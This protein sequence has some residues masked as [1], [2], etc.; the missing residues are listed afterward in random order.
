MKSSLTTK[1]FLIFV[2]LFLPISLFAQVEFRG[3]VLDSSTQ[4]GVPHASVFLA[5]STI[6]ISTDVNGFFSLLIPD[7]D[8]EVIVRLVGYT[9][10][11]FSLSTL[12]INPDGFVIYLKPS[13]GELDF[14]EVED[15]RDPIWY[16]NLSLF[17]Q[18][19]LG[20]T[21]NGKETRILNQNI[22]RLDSESVPL[23]LRV[24]TNDVLQIENPNL[25]YRVEY[26]LEEFTYSI[27]KGTFF[28]SGFSRFIPDS[29]LKRSK[30]KRIESNRKRAYLGSMQHL[31]KSLYDGTA[32]DEGFEFRT[33]KRIKNPGRPDQSL[34]DESKIRF[35]QSTNIEEKDSLNKYF[36]RKERLNPFVDVLKDNLV[37]FGDLVRIEKNGRIF[38]NFEDLLHVT[39]TKE[40]ETDEYLNQFPPKKP[41]WQQ[42]ILRLGNN[43][44]IEIFG[45]GTYGNR[46]GI[47][48]EGY[49]GWE[50]VGDLMPLDYSYK[51]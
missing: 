24:N 8:Y 40:L 33:I 39:F 12:N 44:E 25:G 20:N 1:H 34:I 13:Y 22:L 17:K 19:F 6:G 45:N 15:Q 28:Y 51:K 37:S 32:E 38:L 21:K 46:S 42:S 10:K 5:G 41:S 48:L 26:L 50:K 23:T 27:V 49:L 30:G 29:T 31:I 3:R 4:S 43:N 11:I 2:Y 16:E 9:P 7:G 18:Y 47:F 14:L 35:A 36:L